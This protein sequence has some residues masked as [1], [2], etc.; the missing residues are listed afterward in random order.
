MTFAEPGIPTSGGSG[1]RYD[2]RMT[3]TAATASNSHAKLMTT[4]YAQQA[5]KR[6]EQG[7]GMTGAGSRVLSAQGLGS[8]GGGGGA[9]GL[10][11]NA[12]A[13]FAKMSAAYQAQ[14]GSALQVNSGGRTYAQQA[15]AR[16]AYLAGRGNLAAPAGTSVHE[17]GRAVDLGGAIQN[18]NSPQHRW[19]QS[20]AGQYGF[21]W[22]GRT[23][24]QIE[25]WHWEYVGS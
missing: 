20:V 24:S 19:L 10:Q 17:T 13:A 5:K 8:A 22:T 23:F 21:S 4:I 15:A 14:W 25:P 1:L 12:A 16:A 7:R 6:A 2:E 18:M 3:D 11:K 9:Y